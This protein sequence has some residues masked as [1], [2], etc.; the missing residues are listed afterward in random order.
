MFINDAKSFGRILKNYDSGAA[1][2]RQVEFTFK[3]HRDAMDFHINNL[4]KKPS[5][6]SIKKCLQQ[7]EHTFGIELTVE[8][9]IEILFLFPSERIKLAVFGL[10]DTEVRE[11]ISNVIWKFFAGCEAPTY[12]DEIDLDRFMAHLRSQA[13]IMGYLVLDIDEKA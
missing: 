7:I 5:E 10:P 1:D 6:E 4:S 13:R 9:F 8:Q 11:G 3:L 12:G 2:R